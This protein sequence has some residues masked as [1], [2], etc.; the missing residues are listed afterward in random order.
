MECFEIS[1][2]IDIFPD[3]IRKS[4]PCSTFVSTDMS[5]SRLVFSLD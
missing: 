1:G 3:G 4:V 5:K 2:S